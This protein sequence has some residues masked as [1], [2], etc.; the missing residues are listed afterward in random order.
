MALASPQLPDLKRAKYEDSSSSSSGEEEEEE[1]IVP[2]AACGGPRK[3]AALFGSPTA[4]SPPPAEQQPSRTRERKTSASAPPKLMIR[5]LRVYE[6]K[7]KARKRK[8]TGSDSDSS[9]A[10]SSEDEQQ[11]S[12][13]SSG[14]DRGQQPVLDVEDAAIRAADKAALKTHPILEFIRAHMPVK[15]CGRCHECT[16]PACGVCPNCKAS[17]GLNKRSKGR[18]RCIERGCSK[19]TPEEL[20]RYRAHCHDDIALEKMQAT[21]MSI[22]EKIMI[23]KGKVPEAQLQE[24]EA[25]QAMLYTKV[26][27]LQAEKAMREEV[28]PKEY[29]NFLTGIMTLETER[30]RSARLVDRRHGRDAP[31]AMNPR[32]RERDFFGLKLCEF[33]KMFATEVIAR[34]YVAELVALAEQCEREALAGTE[35]SPVSKTTRPECQEQQVAEVEEEE[36]C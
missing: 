14:S 22:R 33:V 31:D 20:S 24:I 2:T 25:Q 10:G 36:Q 18:R 19:M 21:L 9:S 3:C 5:R 23:S 7:G 29:K 32:R 35:L 11:A 34:P 12:P 30:D 8:A 4:L 17:Q 13:S 6:A 28:M 1:R 26:Q 15:P 16:E 27:Q